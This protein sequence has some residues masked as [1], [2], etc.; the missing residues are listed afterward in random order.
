[1]AVGGALAAQ[2][3]DPGSAL[4]GGVAAGLGVRGALGAA[5]LAGKYAPE[6]FSRVQDKALLPLTEKLEGIQERIPK[7][8]NIRSS[9]M[10]AAIAPVEG[11]AN[12]VLN[13]AQQRALAKGTA[14]VGVP[15]AAGIAGLGGIAAGAIPGAMGIPGFQQQ[16]YVDPESYGSSNTMGARASTTTSQ[17]L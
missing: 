6:L 1:L 7:G 14:A 10:Q 9:F 8:S 12:A 4:L 5:R 11:M 3:E 17:Y 13:P 16:Q 15:L 2:G